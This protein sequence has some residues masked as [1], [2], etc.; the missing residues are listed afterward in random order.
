MTDKWWAEA[1][2]RVNATSSCACLSLI[3]FK[4]LHRVH[5]TNARLR[6][7]F[8]GTSDTSDGCGSSTADHTH[9][10]FLYRKLMS[11]G[12][13][14]LMLGEALNITLEPCCLIAIFGVAYTSQSH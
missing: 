1:L 9:V 12:L 14:S 10:F 4:V 6:R 5:S 8:P 2:V 7:L 13:V 3:Q 11:S